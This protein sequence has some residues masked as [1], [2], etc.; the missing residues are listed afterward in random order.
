MGA[1]TLYRPYA[2]IS[3][4]VDGPRDAATVLFLHGAALDHRAWDKQVSALVDR[5]RVVTV[6]LRN[7]GESTTSAPFRFDDAVDDVVALLDVLRSQRLAL[8][9][10]SLGG[11]IAQEVVHRVP[12][13]VDALVVAD[14]T[15]NHARRGVVQRAVAIAAVRGLAFYPRWLFLR[16]AARVTAKDRAARRYVREATASMPQRDA[17]R[18]LT[19]LLTGALHSDPGY[20]LPIPTLLVHGARDRIGDIAASSRRWARRQRHVELVVIPSA[21]HLSNLD[22]PHAFN[23]ALTTFFDRFLPSGTPSDRPTNT[24]TCSTGS[25]R[26]R[27]RDRLRSI[28]RRLRAVSSPGPARRASRRS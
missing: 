28:P 14:A 10:L 2:S 16:A 8:V 25:A 20:Q 18:V 27:W 5:Y 15:D 6:D 17:L 26:S 7:H 23:A 9:G 11:N 24:S 4:W 13:R 19:S 3:Y 1:R 22:A 21:S 12:E